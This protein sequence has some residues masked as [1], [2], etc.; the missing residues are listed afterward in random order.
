MS[1]QPMR[2]GEE[3]ILTDV[4][5]VARPPLLCEEHGG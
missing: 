4:I 1:S 3:G 2:A 5:S